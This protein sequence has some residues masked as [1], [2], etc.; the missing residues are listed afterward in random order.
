M[1]FLQFL[2]EILNIGQWGYVVV[3]FAVFID[4]TYIL[5][6]FWVKNIVFVPNV[7]NFFFLI[8]K[9]LGQKTKFFHQKNT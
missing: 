8:S 7:L 5:G 4:F 6:I 9:N 2:L 1:M 3:P